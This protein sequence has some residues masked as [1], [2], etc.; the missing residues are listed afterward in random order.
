MCERTKSNASWAGA[1]NEARWLVL[2]GGI[3]RRLASDLV[4]VYSWLALRM[5]H[6]VKDRDGL[7]IVHHVN[8]T[9]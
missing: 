1:R 6:V 9:R 8:E 5:I 2:T 4:L 7:A 3:L